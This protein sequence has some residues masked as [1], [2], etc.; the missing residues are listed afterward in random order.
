MGPPQGLVP[1]DPRSR[2]RGIG[3]PR[4]QLPL[5]I[6]VHLYDAWQ[7]WLLWRPLI[8]FVMACPAFVIAALL[9][10]RRQ[11]LASQERSEGQSNEDAR[12]VLYRSFAWRIETGGR[13]QSQTTD[14]SQ[15]FESARP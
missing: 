2:F 1:S 3:G 5:A 7:T 13:G 10:L 9:G 8:V 15:R 12:F 11:A 6:P 14:L 4:L